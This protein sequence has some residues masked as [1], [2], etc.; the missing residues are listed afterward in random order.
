MRALLIGIAMA[1]LPSGVVAAPRQAPA[2]AI[3][4]PQQL[5]DPAMAEKLGRTL[6]GLTN[7]LLDLKVGEVEAAAK[8][9]K[10]TPAERNQTVGDLVRRDD[11]GAERD[12]R[13]HVAEAGPKIAQG[14]KALADAMP[15][16]TRALDDASRAI[17]RAVAN[18]PDP[19][20]PKR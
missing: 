5:T 6:D 3:E 10:A 11:P 8:G 7:A 2:P 17:D 13:R 16:I 15:A 1:A 20:Y 9:R 12:L 14:M 18:M 4:V 19:T